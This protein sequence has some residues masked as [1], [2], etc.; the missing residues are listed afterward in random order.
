MRNTFVHIK[1]NW[2][3]L[4]TKSKS[5]KVVY[6]ELIKRQYKVFLPTIE[7]VRVW[8]NRQKKTIEKVLL[9]SYLFVNTYEHKL[10]EIKHIQHVVTYLHTSGKPAIVSDTDI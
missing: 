7:E 5:E 10:H 9:P 3:I 6:K 1:P 4:Y 8:K 2:Y